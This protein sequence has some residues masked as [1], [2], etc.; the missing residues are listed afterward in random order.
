MF[1]FNG[2]DFSNYIKV[3]KVTRPIMAPQSLSVTN[4]EGRSGSTLHRKTSSSFSIP[5]EF[6]L[7][8]TNG[9]N[10]RG[11]LREL[12]GLLDSDVPG[13]LIFKDENDKF[14]NAIISEN[15]DFEEILKTKGNGAITFFCADPY[16]YA[17]QD[18]EFTYTDQNEKTFDRKG[19][20]ISYPVYTI[21]GQCNKVSIHTNGD[22]MTV[23]TPLSSGE[24]LIID[25][26][27][28]TAYI[29]KD[30]VKRSVLMHLD[31]LDFPVLKQKGNKVK[32]TVEGTMSKYIVKCNSKWK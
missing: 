9:K 13:R 6:Y 30:G 5:I 11:Q 14:I 1:I 16:W 17:I 23:N 24:K 32:V 28:L 31:N 29:E 25:S 3:T 8:E 22:V 7:K 2:I 20:A 12:A 18:D 26:E 4:I 15:L 19:T 21:E 10:L 27:K